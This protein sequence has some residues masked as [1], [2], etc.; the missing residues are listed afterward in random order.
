MIWEKLGQ[1]VEQMEDLKLENEKLGKAIEKYT[2]KFK[3]HEYK[4]VLEIQTRVTKLNDELTNL[5]EKASEKVII[6]FLGTTSSGKSS[7]INCLLRDDRLPVDMLQCTMNSIHVC[8]TESSSWSV[9]VDEKLLENGDDKETVTRLLNTMSD[10]TTKAQRKDLG[11]TKESVVKV[12]WPKDQCTRLPHNVVLVDT[13]GYGENSRS[14][15]VVTDSC[16]K[17]DIIVTVM[18]IDNPIQETVSNVFSRFK[19]F[20]P[21]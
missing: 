20:S 12:F 14:T 21:S 3:L 2:D 15:K 17:A 10:K 6:E 19:A 1:V 18:K 7:L 4:N 5:K 16:K 8:T 13:P 11:I 9:F